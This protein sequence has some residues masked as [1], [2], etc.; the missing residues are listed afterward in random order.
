MEKICKYC[1][2]SQNKNQFGIYTDP[3]TK[4][5]RQRHKCNTCRRVDEAKRYKRDPKTKER[6]KL[7]ARRTQLKQYG[8]TLDCYDKLFKKQKGK[9]KICNSTSK[10]RLNVDHC[11]ETGKVRGLLCW[12]CNIA[13]GYFKDNI[14]YLS[15]AIRYLGG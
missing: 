1:K 9:C 12:N 14:N 10:K 4:K 11:H 15:N 13:L 5:K 3:R 7:S 6:M 8:L 2:V